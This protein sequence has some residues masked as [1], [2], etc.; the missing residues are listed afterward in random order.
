MMSTEKAPLNSSD[1]QVLY[2]SSGF[3][4]LSAIDG[5]ANS[6]PQARSKYRIDNFLP[7]DP[8]RWMHRFL[9]LCLM[10]SLS[11][12][13]YYCY[14][15]PAA[16][17]RT[18]IQVMRVDNTQYNLLYSLYSW[19]NVILSLIGGVLIDRWIGVRI[20]TVLFSVFV[21]VGQ[22]IFALGGIFD[23]FWLMLVGRFVFGL[24][25]E[26][27]AVAQNAYAVLWFK[28]KEL[29]FVFGA[30][31][32]ISRVGSTVNMNVNQKMF[33][34]FDG[35]HSKPVRLGVV[36]LVGFG[37]CIFSLITGVALGLFDRRAA[38][39]VK[40]KKGEGEKISLRDV[41]DFSLSLWLI[42]I[43]CVMYYVTVF[44]FI[45]V[46]TV[47]LEDKY[48]MS[49]GVANIVNSIVYFMS[50][51]ASP[52]FGIAVDRIGCNLFWLIFGVLATL[53]CHA[54]FAFGNGATYIPFL[55]MLG[56]GFAYSILACSLWPLVA[57]IVPE[58]QLGT[59]YG[60][61]QSV[62]NL[63]LA[64]VPIVNGV[65]ID[66][67]G[68]LILEVFFCICLCVTMIA[69]IALYLVDSV[70]Y[71]GVLNLSY[72]ERKKIADE[73]KNKDDTTTISSNGIADIQAE[74]AIAA[75]PIRPMSAFHV[76]NRLLSRMGAQIP[77]HVVH[78]NALTAS[79]AMGFHK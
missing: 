21:T 73:E 55:A 32:S 11:F 42:F 51:L 4:G 63:G 20:G 37:F 17:T 13:S 25:G 53:G 71:N 61:M 40:R 5:S 19:P 75:N 79:M 66:R 58:H 43:V 34:T 67:V 38:R 44:P 2:G 45:G 70:K 60:L 1:P 28:G 36:L 59:A 9:M 15:N 69:A 50:A 18:I 64:I 48:G 56:M 47:F 41:K 74:A 76:R 29:N 31:L 39:I 46:A 23:K 33:D 65:I 27:L 52:V 68:Y 7:C 78:V 62:Q 49:P 12:G 3:N 77:D 30:L 24:G 6:R 57:F 10:C 26:S 14:D 72:W 54:A 22:L 35:I 16:L 8:R